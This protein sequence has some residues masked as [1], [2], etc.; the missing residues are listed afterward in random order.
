[1]K[2]RQPRPLASEPTARLGSPYLTPREA[3]A[4]LRYAAVSVLYQ[5]VRSQGIPVCRRGRS[6]LFHRE[7]LDRWLAGERAADLRAE[8]RHGSES[9]RLSLVDP[10]KG[11]R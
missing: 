1:M 11:V 6:L 9:A 10:A 8:A 4:Y 2:V 5:A 3:A 7:Q